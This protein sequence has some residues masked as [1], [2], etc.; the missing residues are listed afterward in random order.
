MKTGGLN[1]NIEWKNGFQEG[2]A[3]GWKAAKT[4]LN[5]TNY[6][7]V[8]Y[9]EYKPGQAGTYNIPQF[10]TMLGTY[11]DHTVNPTTTKSVY[12]ITSHTKIV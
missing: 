7:P 5:Y 1:M 2:F 4:E 8:Y 6:P 9:G 10:S 3:A 11:T 12:N